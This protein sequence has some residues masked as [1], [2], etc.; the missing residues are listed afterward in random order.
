MRENYRETRKKNLS[1]AAECE[2]YILYTVWGG[3]NAKNGRDVLV[4]KLR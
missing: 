1:E 3:P 2:M 4:E